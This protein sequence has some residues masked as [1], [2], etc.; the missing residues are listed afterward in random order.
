VPPRGREALLQTNVI[1][2]DRWRIAR[3][4]K[5]EDARPLRARGISLFVR[6]AFCHVLKITGSLQA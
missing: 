6:L 5:S 1:S 2:V 4:A 3:D